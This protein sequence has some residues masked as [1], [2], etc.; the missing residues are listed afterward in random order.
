MYLN[1]SMCEPVF[2]SVYVYVDQRIY[3]PMYP[4]MFQY[5]S[6]YVAM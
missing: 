6:V 4:S 1:V 5:S 2:C 3:L